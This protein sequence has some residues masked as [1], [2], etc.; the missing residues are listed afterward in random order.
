MTTNSFLTGPGEV[1]ETVVR[2]CDVFPGARDVER[3]EIIL[4]KLDAAPELGGEY[5]RATLNLSQK[6]RDRARRCLDRA[7]HP[8]KRTRKSKPS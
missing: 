5:W 2:V 3:C 4:R 1:P 8:V 6:A 7:L